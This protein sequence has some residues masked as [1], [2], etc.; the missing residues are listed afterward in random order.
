MK[1]GRKEARGTMARRPGEKG[2]KEE[3][4]LRVRTRP[5]AVSRVDLVAS[6]RWMQRRRKVWPYEAR[7]V[8]DAVPFYTWL[9][10]ACNREW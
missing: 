4:R 6:R 3:G 10:D 7:G 1:S 9:T 2:T 5:A 8:E